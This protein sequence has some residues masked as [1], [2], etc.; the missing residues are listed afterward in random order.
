M[1]TWNRFIIVVLFCSGLSVQAD[2]RPR[3]HFKSGALSTTFPVQIQESLVYVPVEINGR[4]LHFVLDTGSS[5][6]LVDTAQLKN[7]HLKVSGGDTLQGAGQGRVR[8]QAID[9]LTVGLPGLEMYFDQA[10]SV[11]LSSVNKDGVVTKD[12]L[13][14]YP[15]L[16]RYV[17]TIDYERKV[18]TVTAP[19]KFVAPAGSM[20][21]AIEIRHGWPFVA[22]EVMPSED[23]TLQDRFFI[24]SGS[25]DAVDHPI[26]TKI[27]SRKATETGVGLGTSTSGSV[28]ELWG[29]RLGPYLI[30][31]VEVACC[32]STEDTERMLGGEI[33]SRFTVT[34]DYPH[35]RMFL[36]PNRRYTQSSN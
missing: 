31:D 10:S 9:G 3:D 2:D 4:Q 21:L 28:A 17:V 15:L 8:V 1:P 25:S 12:G 36:F 24:D 30:R 22:G 27:Q 5:R 32:G 7:L 18:M 16:A 26:A 20:P 6:T 13:L 19:E 34:F 11:D 29:F 14:G 33:L 23:V 35:Q